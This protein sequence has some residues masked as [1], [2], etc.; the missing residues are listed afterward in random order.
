MMASLPFPFMR[1]EGRGER[2][3]GEEA[4]KPAP[5]KPVQ[6]HECEDCEPLRRKAALYLKIIERYKDYIEATE[7]KSITELRTLVVPDNPVVQRVVSE[8]KSSFR[9]YIHERD[10]YAASQKAFEYCRDVLRN[11]F[12]PLQFWLAP[13]DLDSLKA[14]DEIDKAIFLCSM[15]VALENPGAKVVVEAGEQVRHAF[16]TFEFSGEF[17][18]MD[19]THGENL[20]G[21]REEVL[22]KP[23]KDS[24][25]MLVYEFNDREYDEWV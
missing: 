7:D 9:P 13:E 5:E 19:P 21:A 4:A 18:L 10:F 14:C 22:K 20:K 17:H 23:L 12:L 2:Q 11:E 3:R 25:R 15:L 24:K 16:V 6:A 8:I 1:R